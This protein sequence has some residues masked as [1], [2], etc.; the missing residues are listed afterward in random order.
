M[1]SG[2]RP[3][4]RRRPR[5]RRGRK[6]TRAAPR[7]LDGDLRLSRVAETSCSS[8]RASEI[9]RV[10]AGRTRRGAPFTETLPPSSTPDAVA[11][12]RRDALNIELSLGVTA[13]RFNAAGASNTTT[14]PTE[15]FEPRVT[16]HHQ[17]IARLDRGRHGQRWN[18]N[19][20]PTCVARNPAI[21]SQAAATPAKPTPV[22]AV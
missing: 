9:A 22:N 19:N 16:L 12:D 3:S 13:H 11:G 21:A 14:S 15:G 17:R 5:S 6:R 8:A 20:P 10:V 4:S 2:P 1:R 7:A 18:L